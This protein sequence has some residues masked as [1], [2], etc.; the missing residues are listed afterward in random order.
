MKKDEIALE[1]TGG[2]FPYLS[3]LLSVITTAV[4]YS[5]VMGLL[6]PLII[7]RLNAQGP[8]EIFI[9]LNSALFAV[10]TL[11]AAPCMPFAFKRI[12]MSRLLLLSTIADTILIVGL[13]YFDSLLAWNVIRFL[14]GVSNGSLVVVISSWVM[15]LTQAGNRARILG[16]LRSLSAVG[17]FVGA[18]ALVWIGI[19]G[20]RAFC[21]V[22][23]LIV[24]A[25]IT[26]LLT[27]PCYISSECNKKPPQGLRKCFH[28][29]SI[30]IVT[31]GFLAFLGAGSTTL[32]P[33]YAIRQGLNETQATG[34]MSAFMAGGV[35]WP[36]AA[37]WLADRWQATKV[38][39]LSSLNQL[40]ALL[41][42]WLMQADSLW[43]MV[44]I[45]SSFMA[46]LFTVTQILVSQH[47]SEMALVEV[48]AATNIST[49]LGL[50]LGPLAVGW[51][52]VLGGT[53]G[54]ILVLLFANIL[55]F[56]FVII[57]KREAN[58]LI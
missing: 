50:L 39:W 9:G 55:F 41:M 52:M 45:W 32:L 34:L 20:L 22:I 2:V 42:L 8:S 37:A 27:R 56:G 15:N 1:K 33:V 25:A 31:N 46:G 7:F 30:P 23:G 3:P 19:E 5:I 43:L 14:L 58:S 18:T 38:W 57:Q 40:A 51:G 49:G 26:M 48:N 16:S 53:T 36:L 29:A 6:V 10:G 44:F 24:V 4:L 21:F 11:L 47:F 54:F 28:R 17:F 13:M 12:A 35:F